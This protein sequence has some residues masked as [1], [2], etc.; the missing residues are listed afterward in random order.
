MTVGLVSTR[1]AVDAAHP[2][3]RRAEVVAAVAAGAMPYADV[4]LPM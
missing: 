3:G 1:D 4:P 2:E